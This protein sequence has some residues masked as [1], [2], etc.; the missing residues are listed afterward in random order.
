MDSRLAA[1]QRADQIGV[2]RE[3]VERL[4]NEGVLALTGEEAS[5]LHVYH[6]QLLTDF[7][8]AFDIDRNVAAKQL[9][10]GMR[11]ASL[12]AALALAASVFFLFYRFWG[13]LG[14]T[15]EIIVLVSASMV[16]YVVT[17]AVRK[18]DPAGYFS[19]LAATV[20]FVCFVLNILMLGEI[21][22]VTPS[23]SAL[24]AWAVFAFFLAYHCDSRL[25]LA[26]GIVCVM[27]YLSARVGEWCGI[28]WLDLGQRPENFLPAAGMLF[29][30]PSLIDHR[31]H[32]A[33]AALYRVLAL[34][35]L[36]LPILALSFYGGGSYLNLD[37][38]SIEHGYQ[39]AGFG[40][41]VLVIAL[42]IR[43]AWSG[44]ANTGV[45]F[46]LIFLYTKFF[47]W[48][49]ESMPKYLFFLVLGLTAILALLILWRLRGGLAMSRSWRPT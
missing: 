10:L 25:L 41:S 14:E 11:V 34:V 5:T 48:W 17:L 27:G 18:R 29:L 6:E 9:S 39:L 38:T 45:V 42:G 49:W 4:R 36:F 32:S 3:E 23:Y 16:T 28:Y 37:A 22:N 35:G 15:A 20:A 13:A 46:F 30:V 21:F 44:V 47:D 19:T 7:A 43:R 12:L 2:F 31:R 33:F 24:L 1:Q 40:L 26:A 8:N